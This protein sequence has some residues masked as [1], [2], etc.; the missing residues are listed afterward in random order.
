MCQQAA[1]TPPSVPDTAAAQ[2]KSNIDTAV[3]Q[4]NLNAIDQTTPTGT[5]RYT[6]TGTNPDGTPHYLA[7]STLTPALQTLNDTVTSAGQNLADVAKT[8]SGKIGGLLSQPFDLSGLPSAGD[9]NV[10][11]PSYDQYGAAPTLKSSIDN[12]GAI[13][14]NIA[15][16]G[17]IN[18]TVANAGNIASGYDLGGNIKDTIAPAGSIQKS[19]GTNDFSADRQRV[20]DA[21]FGE[22]DK[23]SAKDATTLDSQLSNQGIARGSDAYTRAMDDFNKSRTANR[24]SA[25]LNAGTEQNRLQ[26][27]ALNAG[28]FANSAEAQQYGQ[29][30]NDLTTFNSAQ[31][32][33]NNEN[34]AL[35]GFGN[36]AQGQ[37]YGQNSNDVTQALLA[38]A[39]RYGQNS[40]DAAF[41]NT[42]QAQRYG[43]NANDATFANTAASADF[44][45]RA[46]VTSGNNALK[47]S[48]LR[49][50]TSAFDL[51]NTAR[52]NALNERYAARSQPI[53]EI[54]A[55][56]GQGGVQTPTFT[57][58]PSTGVAGTDIAGL[59]NANYAQQVAAT[60][61]A[62]AN[63]QATLG[64]LFGIGTSLL[65]L[66]D[67]RTKEDIRY[68]GDFTADGIP[69]ADY[70]YAWEP[71][72]T[73]RHGVIAQDVA[74]RR[75]DAVVRIGG[76]M[77]VDARKIPE[78]V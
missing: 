44:A 45:N 19:L 33:R 4:T 73:L 68:T 1:P 70:R 27:L 7:T 71:E 17:P 3:A 75:P 74:R 28:N 18:G 5:L 76:L 29:N 41:A 77:A 69:E 66:S 54:L 43:Q 35:A 60:N 34:A 78:A 37:R 63:S 26:G 42:A 9:P 38:Q 16:A 24:T 30:A 12:A 14:S 59:T 46:A 55:L 62:N 13:T 61:A 8:E 47:D 31:A 20:E 23:Q 50:Q 11:M 52:T 67:E 15:N 48:T 32:Q 56:A 57:S 2:T 40:N 64:G 36:A 72:G 22:L 21:L 39:Q 10:T 65:K 6:T 49:N 53:N 58:T 51:A 25:I